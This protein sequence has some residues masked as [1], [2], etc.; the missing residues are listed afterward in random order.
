MKDRLDASVDL[1]IDGGYA[2]MEPTSVIDISE[3]T[4]ILIRKGLGDV[5]AFVD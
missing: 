3:D 4:P 1:I 5:S 2:G